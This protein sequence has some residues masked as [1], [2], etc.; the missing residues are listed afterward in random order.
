[1]IICWA[2]CLS[3]CATS[4]HG[5]SSTASGTCTS[6]MHRGALALKRH[7]VLQGQSSQAPQGSGLD[8]PAPQPEQR[9]GADTADDPGELE[10]DWIPARSSRRQAG[11][12]NLQGLPAGS[13][14]GSVGGRSPVRS[15]RPPQ[16]PRGKA[17]RSTEGSQVSLLGACT[18]VIKGISDE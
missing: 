16:N 9:N 11:R 13:H 15:P 8:S 6:L 3:I 12:R 4:D 5:L 17:Q 1:M 18:T 10:G 7:C 14:P 2:V